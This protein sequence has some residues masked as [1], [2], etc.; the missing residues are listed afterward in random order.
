M[1]D[2][3]QATALKG[4]LKPLCVPDKNGV[5]GNYEIL[6]LYFDTPDLQFYRDKVEGVFTREKIRLRFYRNNLRSEWH[7]PTLELKKKSGVFTSK[8]RKIM[9]DFEITNLPASNSLIREFN[10]K[11]RILKPAALVFYRRQ[12]YFVK[13][14]EGLRVTF[15]SSFAAL[16]ASRFQFAQDFNFLETAQ[17]QRLP[18]VFEIK[19]YTGVPESILQLPERV[20]AFQTSFSKYATAINLHSHNNF[21]LCARNAPAF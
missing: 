8:Q 11:K 16:P 15:D 18:Q 7:D 6:S 9:Q 21:N 4:I 3:S 2:F 20:K 19:S 14:M 12:A 1:I 13:G 10:Q 17:F 5:N